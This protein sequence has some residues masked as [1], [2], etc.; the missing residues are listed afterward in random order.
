[1]STPAQKQDDSKVLQSFHYSQ[2]LRRT[3]KLFSSF[4][5]AFSFISITTGIFTNYSFVLNT[6]GPMGIW[7]WPIVAVGHLLVAIIFA[8]LAGRI[9]LSGYSYQWVTRLTNRGL[10]WFSGWIAFCFL[11]IVVPTVDYGLAPIVGDLLG[12]GTEPSTLAMIVIVTLAIQAIINIVGVKIASRINNTAV[13]TE[14]IGMVGIILVIGAIVLFAGKA[15]WGMLGN[16]GVSAPEGSYLGA[17][18]MA[19]LMGSYTL[20][21]FE[22]AANLSE[23]TINARNNV[24][25]AII[26]SVFLSGLIGTLFLIVI[27]IAIPDLKAVT[28]SANPIPYIL[29]QH[30]GSSVTTF[31]L[32]LI[33]ISIFACGLVIMVSG[34]RLIYAM[35]RDGVFFASSVFKRVSPKTAVPIN[36]TLLILALGIV[37]VIFADSLTLLVGAT[38]VLPASLYLITVASYAWK[39]KQMEQVDSFNLGKWWVPLSTLTILWLVFE[40]G[41]LTIPSEFHKVAIVAG[42]LMAVGI[43]IYLVFFRKAILDGRIGIQE[44]LTP[45][46]KAGVSSKKSPG[47]GA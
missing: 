4:A 42:V 45:N 13:Y 46:R 44:Q 23:E 32:I 20:V 19:A 38:A 30:L 22:A 34:S 27:S 7:T 31:V 26:S 16:T 9:P 39:R 21:G 18:I 33:I 41:I 36:A 35:S 29:E 11:A 47:A 3:L 15:D 10:G 8:E 28:D 24:P 40:I 17:F 2:E 5:V 6:A 25:K 43:V 37:A 14:V 12:I 1:M